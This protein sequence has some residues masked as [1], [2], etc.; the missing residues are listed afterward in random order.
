MPCQVR[1]IIDREHAV[2]LTSAGLPFK[3]QT[4][5]EPPAESMRK[6]VLYSFCGTRSSHQPSLWSVVDP[7]E[8]THEGFSRTWSVE[9]LSIVC[10]HPV[11]QRCRW[12]WKMLLDKSIIT[13]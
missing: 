9:P 11:Q 1:I 13:I 8:A 4:V 7:M 3:P 6:A 12:L 10:G 2:P 5:K